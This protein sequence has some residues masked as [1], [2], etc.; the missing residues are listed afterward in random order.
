M[1]EFQ[2]VFYPLVFEPSLHIKVWGGRELEWRLGKKLPTHEPYGES[3]EI[4]W[5]NKVANGSKAGRTL[6]E[7]IAAYPRAMVGTDH[8][9]AE[10]P[11]LVKFIDAQDWLSVQVHPDDA[12]A[13]ELEGE[14]RGKTECWY[15]V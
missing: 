7:L 14:P 10:Y 6:G 1:S 3:W 5:K 12:R 2:P 4:F 15:I 8:A 13:A 11:L 9:D